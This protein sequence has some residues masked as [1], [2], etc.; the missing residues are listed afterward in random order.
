ACGLKPSGK[1]DLG[2]VVADA[3]CAA[4]GLFTTNRFARAN[5][6]VCREHLGG[7]IRSLLRHPRQSYGCC[8]AAWTQVALHSC[9]AVA[10]RTRAA[11]IVVAVG[12]TGVIGALPDITLTRAG[13][14]KVELHD[15]GIAE[16]GRAM[17]TTALAPKS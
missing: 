9:G 14:A 8:G 15:G 5:I 10:Q 7:P 12:S 6:P 4:A 16:V 17:M 3:P 11:H 13:I 2:L 1:P